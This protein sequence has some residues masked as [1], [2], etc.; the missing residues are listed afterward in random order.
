MGTSKFP[1]EEGYRI[2]RN[3][4]SRV[5]FSEDIF[6]RTGGIGGM[7]YQGRGRHG[8][9]MLLE[10]FR[11][12]GSGTRSGT[13]SWGSGVGAADETCSS[14]AASPRHVRR[15]RCIVDCLGC[16]ITRCESR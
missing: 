11:G 15:L 12:A 10:A 13:T 16:V 5:V 14:P 3:V 9:V 1:L 4:P 8:A 7:R 2:Y 6:R